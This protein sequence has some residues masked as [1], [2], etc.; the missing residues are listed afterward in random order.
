M[1][2]SQ[3]PNS[4]ERIVL[5]S[6]GTCDT[7][8]GY[9][10]AIL[11]QFNRAT[12]DLMRFP[13]VRSTEGI[14]NALSQTPAPA[15]IVYTFGKEILRKHVWAETR[16]LNLVGFDLMYPAI[17][18]F[19]AFFS[20]RPAE[21]EAAL[22]S[23]QSI[24]YFERMEAIEFTVKHDDGMR[25]SDLAEADLILTGVSRTS[26]TPTAMYLAHKGYKVA[27]VPLVYGIDPPQQLIDASQKGIPV[28]FLKIDP[29]ALEK[30]RRSRFLK[31]GTSPQQS[32]TYV[33]QEAIS[34]ELKVALNLARRFQWRQIDVTNKA[35]EE[36][37]SEIV[38]FLRPHS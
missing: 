5:I 19:G 23:V 7:A 27:N 3:S 14:T 32:D 29:G 12:M 26:K 28:V 33:R 8:E 18:I 36:T 35:I 34:E 21:H 24:N 11:T 10:R 9:V 20:S 22:H 4:S 25:L 17:D 38:V 1:M 37:A 6:D 30:I 15:L 31:L 2:K 13:S 16:R